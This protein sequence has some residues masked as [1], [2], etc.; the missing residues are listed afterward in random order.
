MRFM[1]FLC[2][3]ALAGCATHG[4]QVSADKASQFK[5]G[6]AT[7]WDV[8]TALGQPTSITSAN[9]Q[10][11]LSYSGAQAQV[12]PA[13]F[14][15][16]IGLFAGGADVRYSMTMFKFGADGKLIDVMQTNGASG[17]NTGAAAGTMPPVTDQPRAIE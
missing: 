1:L 11:M 5:P 2:A 4:V 15:P 3:I 16:I 7:E 6:V 8:V 9:G 13:S 10:R 17:M 14:I 12:R